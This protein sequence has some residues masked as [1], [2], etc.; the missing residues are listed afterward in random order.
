MIKRAEAA[1][2]TEYRAPHVPDPSPKAPADDDSLI[3]EL[4][5]AFVN[6][7][8]ELDLCGRN[9]E[10]LP[11][12]FGR[13][14]TLLILDLSTNQLEVGHSVFRL[15]EVAT[16]SVLTKLCSLTSGLTRCDCGA[17]QSLHAESQ[18][19]PAQISA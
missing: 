17:L 9:L 7:Q 5:K 4:Q 6:K 19:Q 13:I 14:Y 8:Q 10:H 3:L 18:L 2:T 11:E 1:L 15:C 16:E 12:S